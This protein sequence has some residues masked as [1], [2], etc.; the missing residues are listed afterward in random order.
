MC[1][2]RRA[3]RD[4]CVFCAVLVSTTTAVSQVTQLPGRW[5]DVDKPNNGVYANNRLGGMRYNY[6]LDSNG[7][8]VWDIGEPFNDSL[9]EDIDDNYEEDVGENWPDGWAAAHDGTC[10]AAAAANLVWYV[11]GGARYERWVHEGI[12][13]D[14]S[15]GPDYLWTSSGP[16]ERPLEADYI[17]YVIHESNEGSQWSIDVPQ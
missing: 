1:L 14:G 4:L 2:L 6:W 13:A 10:W 11:G 8:G 12:Y 17:P 3:L 9:A 5:Y 16:L 7:N 15:T